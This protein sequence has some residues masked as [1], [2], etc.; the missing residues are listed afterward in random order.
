MMEEEE[1]GIIIRLFLCS[2]SQPSTRANANHEVAIDQ[3]HPPSGLL[4][5]GGWRLS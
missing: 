3:S 5:D 4:W 2:S 1:Q